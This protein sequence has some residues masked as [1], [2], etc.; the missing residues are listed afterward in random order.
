MG[1]EPRSGTPRWILIATGLVGLVAA[2][3]VAAA[4]YYEMHKARVEAA[5][6]HPTPVP[7]TDPKPVSKPGA[8]PK[9]AFPS[10]PKLDK[11]SPS[12]PSDP[13][14]ALVGDY[15][16]RAGSDRRPLVLGSGADGQPRVRRD[17]EWSRNWGRVGNVWVFDFGNVDLFSVEPTGSGQVRWRVYWKESSGGF[18]R[19]RPP[20]READVTQIFDRR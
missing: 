14:V 3:F 1:D 12:G 10:S 19:D 7:P 6:A 15:E 16:P 8:G 20:I 4:R 9:D 2:T 5:N 13:W 11:N 18:V 17:G